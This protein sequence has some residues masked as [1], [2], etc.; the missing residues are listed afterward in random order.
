[1]ATA[2]KAP[3]KK[4]AHT[5]RG[6]AQDRKLVSAK[7]AYDVSY[8]SKLSKKSAADVTKAIEEK[9]HLVP[10]TGIEPVFAA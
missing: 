4:A 1:M 2:K 8:V 3:A 10:P 5:A 6:L 7:Q 9:G